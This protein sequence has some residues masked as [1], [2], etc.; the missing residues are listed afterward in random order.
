MNNRVQY[1][2]VIKRLIEN[3]I[4]YEEISF[5]DSFKLIITEYAGRVIGPFYKEQ[6]SIFWLN[7]AFNDTD[8]FKKLITEKSWNLGAER[9]WIAPEFAFFN[10]ERADFF[11]SYIVQPEIDP[12]NYSMTDIDNGVC[13]KD[14]IKAPVYEMDF[15]DKSFEIKRSIT[16]ANNPLTFLKQAKGLKVAY[17]GFNHEIMIK[18][19]SIKN[20]MPLEP[21]VL[22]QI[23]PG[24]KLIIPFFG[25]FEFV[26]YYEPINDQI[27]KVKE[28][29]VEL[30]ICGKRRFKVA[31]KAANTF[32]RAAYVNKLDEE[33]YYLIV[34]NYDN[35]PSNDYCCE[36]YNKHGEKGC[37]LYVYNDNGENGGFAEFEN[38]GSTTSK[39]RN[40]IYN[41]FSQWFFVGKKKELETIIEVL[42][43]IK[44]DMLTL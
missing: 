41:T 43:G 7:S 29:Y 42:L 34:K 21:W 10:K 9:M 37:S 22:S 39:E 38:S 15:K 19:T 4:K 30:D 44:Y 27:Q 1:K 40:T 23:N 6:E 11:N 18:D 36:P 35:N 33:N 12:A 3:D 20:Q 16:T 2:D 8:E 32:G 25:E 26:D 13:L 28:G 31:Y 24:G 14:E 17:C 5:E